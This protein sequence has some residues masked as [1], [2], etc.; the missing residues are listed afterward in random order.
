VFLFSDTI[1]GNIAYGVPEA[2]M[3]TVYEAAKTAAAD[4]FIT[5]TPEGYDTI[6]GERG[7]GL[8]GGQRQRLALARALAIKPSILIL[9]DTTSAVDMETE[10]EIQQALRRMPGRRTLFIIAHRISSVRYADEILVIEDGEVVERG[11][12]DD[13][14]ALRGR[15][16]DIFLTQAGMDDQEFARVNEGGE[17]DGT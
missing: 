3:S 6:I 10:H 11:R 4:D 8:S 5:R 1:E 2:P 17:S 9:D 13:L 16:Y 7:V 14:M 15:Y 12:H